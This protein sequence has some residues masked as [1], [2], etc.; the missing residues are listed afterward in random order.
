MYPAERVLG[1]SRGHPST[2]VPVQPSGTAVQAAAF[3]FSWAIAPMLSMQSLF[4][5]LLLPWSLL[6]EGFCGM[7][8]CHAETPALNELPC[9]VYQEHLYCADAT[10][11]LSEKPHAVVEDA[12]C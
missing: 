10:L 5:G 4:P 1:H 6:T 12:L 8:L 7:G 9:L 2:E 11:D 3:N